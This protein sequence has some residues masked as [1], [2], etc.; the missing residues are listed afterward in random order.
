[1]VSCWFRFVSFWPRAVGKVVMRA[2][3]EHL[4]P[5]TL[6]LGTRP[7]AL[8]PRRTNSHPH[9]HTHHALVLVGGKSPCIIDSK[10]DI[11]PAVRR[12]VWGKFWNAGQTCIAPDYLLV[13]VPFHVR[14]RDRTHTHS[15][16][17]THTRTTAHARTCL[18]EHRC[19]RT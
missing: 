15:S 5:V 13:R 1:M 3:A 9:T 12:V 19:T 6:E 7:A 17:H 2:A 11:D 10:V 14:C 18:G 8:W 16:P 4:T